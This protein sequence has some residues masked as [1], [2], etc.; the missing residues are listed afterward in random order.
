MKEACRWL[1]LKS[2]KL[3]VLHEVPDG[4][5]SAASLKCTNSHHAKRMNSFLIV[6]KRLLAQYALG[7]KEEY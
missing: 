5:A 2:F 1:H 4:G 3:F 6:S 7:N